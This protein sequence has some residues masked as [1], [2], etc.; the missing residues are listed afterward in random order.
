MIYFDNGA[1]TYPKPPRVAFA[2]SNAISNLGGNPGRGGHPM[3]MQAAQ[4]VYNVR[5]MAAELFGLDAPENVI[6]TQNCSHAL[7]LVVYGLLQKGDRVVISDLEH[8][9]VYR[10][11]AW[12]AKQGII[13]LEIVETSLVDPW[14]T[15]E[16]FE[17]ALQ[18]K[19]ALVLC[20]HASNV[21]GTVL[22]IKAIS[23]LAHQR[24]ALF[25]VDGAQ[26]AGI[27]EIDMKD[28]GID[29]LCV[30]GHKGLY[31][32]SGTGMMLCGCDSL[33]EP[34]MRGGTGSL[35]AQQEMPDFYPDR[36]ECGTVNLCG[37]CGL[38]QGLRFI[39][40]KGIKRLY[41]HDFD[42]INLFYQFMIRCNGIEL[43]TPEPRYGWASSVL[44]FNL[45]GRSGEETAQILSEKGF[46]LRGGLHCAPLA[47]QKLGTLDRGT[48]RIGVGAFNTP[49]QV[50]QLCETIKKL[51][52]TV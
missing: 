6:F 38:G 15:L 37:I 10:P 52:D 5:K 29:F 26:S 22:P 8:N 18:K 24:G 43:Y 31:G 19:T 34:M 20:T 40:N 46:A 35:S 32:P 3:A 23:Q 13:E 17:K 7:N 28:M 36:L 42:L 45:K 12:L 47:H 49:A 27:L 50:M 16:S 39:K 11:L 41:A 2:V 33:L 21:T 30:P 44:S 14:Q 48:A 51:Q 25:A 9:S 1:T 4:E